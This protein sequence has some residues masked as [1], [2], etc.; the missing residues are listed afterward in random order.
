MVVDDGRRY[1][2]WTKKTFD[3]ITID[4][5]P[6]VE[7]AGS[8]LLYS[9]EFYALAKIR[10]KPGGILQQWFPGGDSITEAAVL[11]AIIEAFP[12]VRIFRGVGDWGFHM[13]A[14]EQP[15]LQ[16]SAETLA[17]RLPAS[18]NR[19]LVEWFPSNTPTQ[20]FAAMLSREMK[21]EAILG[22]APGAP[23]LQ[24]DRPVNEYYFL[25]RAVQ[26]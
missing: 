10:L 2:Q 12:Y 25:R 15:I 23:V 17:S 18:A 3:V 16:L 26:K 11:Q 24:D 9:R 7:A 14:S 21:A 19:D 6:P 22:R 5:P 4:P 13:L 20:V 1:L 8:S